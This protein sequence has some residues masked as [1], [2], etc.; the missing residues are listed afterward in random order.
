MQSIFRILLD[1]MNHSDKYKTQF[2]IAEGMLKNFKDLPKLSIHELSERCYVS[3]SSMTRFV[4]QIGFSSYKEF[5]QRCKESF[6]I[7]IDYSR[8]VTKAEGED[9][10]PI[11]RSY[12]DNVKDNI[13]YNFEH[14]DYDQM[15]RISEWIYEASEVVYLGL[16]FA[17]ILGQH[18]QIKMAECNKYVQLPINHNDQINTIR[19]LSKK[20][21]VI[22]A[23]VEGS[24]FF[25]NEDIIKEL[26]KKEVKIIAITMEHN[27]KRLRDVDD[28]IL[29]NKYNSETEGRISLLHI[30]ELLLMNYFI[31]YK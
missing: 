1:F 28:I 7:D 9:I 23:S 24:Y 21:V 4:R 22:I 10:L 20:S 2:S 19:N 15:S 26:K 25:I 17:T 18:Y 14:V 27:L 30:L 16:E 29:C 3:P 5:R 31:N 12:S 6:T 11:Y 13:Q 8:T